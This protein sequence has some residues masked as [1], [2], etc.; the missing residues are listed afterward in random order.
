MKNMP[1]KDFNEEI[2]KGIEKQEQNFI[3]K[4]ENLFEDL[5]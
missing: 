1:N 5:I 3:E 2:I 4:I